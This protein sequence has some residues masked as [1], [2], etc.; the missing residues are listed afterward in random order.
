HQSD[1]QLRAAAEDLVHEIKTFIGV[2]VTVVVH[3]AGTIERAPGKSTRL[4]ER[5][6]AA[7]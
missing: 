1:A 5:R 3:R 2:S 4:I 7:R 6:A